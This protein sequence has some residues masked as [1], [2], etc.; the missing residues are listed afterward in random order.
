MLNDLKLTNMPIYTRFGDKGQTSL[1]GG[2]VV[3]KDETRVVAYGEIDE[4]NAVLGVIIAACEYQ[5]ITKMLNE[6]QKDLFTIG[7]ELAFLP[8]NKKIRISHITADRVSDLENIIDK[9]EE[10]LTPLRNFILPGGTKLAALIHLARTV[11]RRAERSTISL[12]KKE[13]INSEIIKYLNRLGDL[14]FVLAR[15][16]N[17]KKRMR[18][19]IWKGSLSKEKL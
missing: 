6:I 10:Q 13:T 2:E 12:N 16:A 11:C 9:I 3:F 18:E 14:L 19:I 5:D 4:L 15:F 7:A 1:L 8:S 17:R